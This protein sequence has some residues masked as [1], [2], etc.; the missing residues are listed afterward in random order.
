MKILAYITG[1]TLFAISVSVSAIPS[2]PPEVP[3]GEEDTLVHVDNVKP[4]SDAAESEFMSDYLG[5]AWSDIW[6]YKV[7]GSAGADGGW[8]AVDD[9]DVDTDLWAFD[10]GGVGVHHFLIKGPAGNILTYKDKTDNTITFT[11]THFL[12]ENPGQ[13]AVI[14]LNAFS[15]T[16]PNGKTKGVT[17]DFVSHVGAVPEPSIVALIGIGL[18]GMA[19][20]HRRSRK[21]N[22]H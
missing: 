5:A 22:L 10:F 20:V 4:S 9:G 11:G 15:R 19:L 14:D 8:F 6:F 12:F 16:L 18:L 3:P 17:I 1:L 21:K 13:Y 7:D 2:I